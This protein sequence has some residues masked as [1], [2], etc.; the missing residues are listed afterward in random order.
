MV[1]RKPNIFLAFIKKSYLLF[2]AS[3]NWDF[4]VA[5]S[6]ICFQTVLSIEDTYCFI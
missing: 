6:K 4:K 3:V 2:V 5:I 1:I